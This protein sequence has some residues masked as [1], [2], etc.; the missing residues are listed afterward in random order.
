[1]KII[2][3]YKWLLIIVL[4]VLAV[5]FFFNQMYRN[6]IEKLTNFSVSYE[7]FDKAISD[8]SGN[9]SDDLGRYTEEAL[10]ELKTNA[11]L[12]ISSLIKNDGELMRAE[13]EVADFS[14]RELASLKAYKEG[15]QSKRVDLGKL[16]K[17]YA[18]IARERK[19]A[20][21]NFQ[22]LTAYSKD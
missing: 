17:D 2:K 20:Y 15:I 16:A 22:E 4:V 3:K 7:K 8:F 13:L 9:T 5:A 11:S 12:K 10:A 21:A 14:T 1:M 19:A 18:D 6:D